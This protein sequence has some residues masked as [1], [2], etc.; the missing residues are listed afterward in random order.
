MRDADVLMVASC[1]AMMPM[2]WWSVPVWPHW[3]SGWFGSPDHNACKEP[4]TAPAGAVPL[5]AVLYD[6]D[7]V[8][9]Y[10]SEETVWRR[11]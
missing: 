9:G 4:G 6:I 1:G 11:W 5:L 7:A 3:G 2:R 8:M 10:T